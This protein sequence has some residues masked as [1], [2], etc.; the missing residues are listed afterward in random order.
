MMLGPFM[1]TFLANGE[2]P[3]ANPAGEQSRNAGA[4]LKA[5]LEELKHEV[6]ELRKELKQR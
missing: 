5:E 3:P 1:R 2:Q 6:E 4:E